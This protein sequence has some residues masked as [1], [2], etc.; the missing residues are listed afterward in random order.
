MS[1]FLLEKKGEICILYCYLR[2]ALAPCV[3]DARGSVPCT[4]VASGTHGSYRMGN[5][6]RNLT[7]KK[8][9]YI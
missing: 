6:F 5:N 8:A 1:S 9:G 7:K 3:F 2:K 4:Q